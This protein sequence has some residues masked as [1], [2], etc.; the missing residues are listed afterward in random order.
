MG[1]S[2]LRRKAQLLHSHPHLKVMPVRGNIDTRLEM[3]ESG[4]LD[5]IVL[6]AAGGNGMH[7][8]SLSPAGL[9]CAAPVCS[10]TSSAAAVSP[11][12]VNLWVLLH[13][14]SRVHVRASVVLLQ[15]HSACFANEGNH[16]CGPHHHSQHATVVTTGWLHV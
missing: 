1:T 6:A 14:R 15:L 12:E 11:G 16:T 2:S 3:L 7:H 8:F 5:A 4:D 13:T 10:L 9:C